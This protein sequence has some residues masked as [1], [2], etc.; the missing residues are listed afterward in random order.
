MVEG[1]AGGGRGLRAI[2][3]TGIVGGSA[4]EV[5]ARGAIAGGE[6]H[7]G[8]GIGLRE[9]EGG[10]HWVGSAKGSKDQEEVGRRECWLLQQKEC[11][12][13]FLT[14]C[15]KVKDLTCRAEDSVLFALDVDLVGVGWLAV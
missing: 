8:V 9:V 7:L 5:E 10:W 15:C 14:V 3:F 2:T 6:D 1:E 11:D 12:I 13:R 4:A